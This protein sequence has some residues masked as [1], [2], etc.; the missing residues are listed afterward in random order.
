[1]EKDI[2]RDYELDIIVRA[3]RDEEFRLQLLKNPKKSIEDEFHI[4]IPQDMNIFVHEEDEMNLHLIVPSLPSNFAANELSDEE[5]KDVIGGVMAAG[6][7][8]TY[9]SGLERAQIRT[10]QDKNAELR[11]QIE[12]LEKELNGFKKS[13]P[14][15]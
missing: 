7:M 11:Q 3:W 10:L 9:P 5:L 6:H 2:I 8:A 4:S 13:G 12:K 14:K 1:M 15:N